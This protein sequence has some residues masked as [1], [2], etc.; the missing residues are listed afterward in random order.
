MGLP[1]HGG[2]AKWPFFG[3]MMIVELGVSLS[4]PNAKGVFMLSPQKYS[5]KLGVSK[6]L[7]DKQKI[8][9]IYKNNKSIKL[10]IT[11]TFIYHICMDMYM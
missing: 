6:P 7:F 10:W 2:T 9:N 5:R 1:R 3:N 11:Y 4:T 8:T